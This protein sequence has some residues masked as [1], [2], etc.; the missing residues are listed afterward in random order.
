M[1]ITRTLLLAMLLGGIAQAS[2]A[3]LL[4]G[5]YVTGDAEYPDTGRIEARFTPKDEGSWSV[6]FDFDFQESDYTF[7]GS[8]T[9]SLVDGTLMGTVKDESGERTFVFTGTVTAGRFEGTHAEI[10]YGSETPTGTMTL[11]PSE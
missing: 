7:R 9:G 1:I 2:E 6:V 4:V 10:E 11:A 8:A 5:S 3:T